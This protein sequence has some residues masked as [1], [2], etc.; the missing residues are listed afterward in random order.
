M[1]FLEKSVCENQSWKPDDDMVGIRENQFAVPFS[2]TQS[3]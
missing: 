2:C 3:N 1:H